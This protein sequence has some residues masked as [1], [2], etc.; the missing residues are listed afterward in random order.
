MWET[1][2]IP[3]IVF[4]GESMILYPGTVSIGE[5]FAES[6]VGKF[7]K[8]TFVLDTAGKNV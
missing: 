8:F 5:I 4:F 2:I 6:E 7:A 3:I 1:V